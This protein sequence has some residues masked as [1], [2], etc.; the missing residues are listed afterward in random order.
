M[1]WPD[2]H[3]ERM[4]ELRSRG[5]PTAPRVPWRSSGL[6]LS[7]VFFVLTSLGVGATYAFFHLVAAEVAWLTTVLCIALAE[8]LIGVRRFF[9]TGVESAL[10]FG[11]LLVLIPELPGKGSNEVILVIAAAAAVAGLRVRNALFGALAAVLVMVYL[12][13]DDRVDAAAWT[14]VGLSIVALAALAREWKRPST[15]RLWA[16]LLIIPSIASMMWSLSAWWALVY[17]TVAIICMGAGLLMR[18]HAPFMAAGVYVVLAASI[19]V[20]HDFLPLTRE[21]SLI[22]SGAILLTTSAIVARDLREKTRGIVVSPDALTAFDEEIQILGTI[23]AQPRAAAPVA[24][25]G[26]GGRF[27]GAGA[28]GDY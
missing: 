10:W 7:L 27:G 2:V 14:G 18:I 3:D 6:F 24:A 1:I 20:A 5:L 9:G 8:Y 4:M 28:T 22:V 11:G 17:V 25:E 12:A 21:W 23:A 13:F 19:A 26:G 15:D 16:A